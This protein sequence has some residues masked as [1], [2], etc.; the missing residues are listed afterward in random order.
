MVPNARYHTQVSDAKRWLLRHVP[1]YAR[2]YRFLL[3][4]PGSDGLMPSLVVDPAWPHPERSVNAARTMAMRVA[5]V[6]YMAAQIG[7]DP[8]LLAKV[9]PTY[10]AVREAHAAGQRHWL[11]T[12]TREN[13]ELVTDP[14]AEITPDGV[15]CANGRDFPVDVIVYATGFPRQ[16]LP[17]ADG[18]RRPGRRQAAR[19]LGRRA[20]SLPRHRRARL[21]EPVL[22]LR[23]GDEPRARGQH[24]LPLGVP[25]A[26]RH[27]LPGR[28]DARRV[29][30]HG[31]P[32]RRARRVQTSASTR[33]TRR[34]SGR[35][36]AWGAGT[37]TRT[38]G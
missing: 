14:I 6:Q 15:R 37:R 7:D 26:L 11:A 31:L 24:H 20:A 5:F 19:A 21:P 35:I 3:F 34:S 12:L 25:G 2:W 13:V 27:G 32:S 9:T 36:P 4:W 22:P 28:A 23:A 10:P 17:L 8:E 30:E 33:A 29:L 38:A 16:S 1:S 18:D